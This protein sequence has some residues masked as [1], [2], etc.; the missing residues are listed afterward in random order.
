MPFVYR[1]FD[2]AALDAAFAAMAGALRFIMIATIPSAIGLVLV[3]V[4]ANHVDAAGQI[5]VRV[6]GETVLRERLERAIRIVAEAV[7]PVASDLRV[8]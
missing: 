7:I 3:D 2:Q 1:D 8:R 4:L 5:Q 6:A